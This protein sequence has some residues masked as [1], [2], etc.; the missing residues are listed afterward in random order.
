M[1]LDGFHLA[2]EGGPW[3]SPG[4]GHMGRAH[5]T[6]IGSGARL[7]RALRQWVPVH[8]TRERPFRLLLGPHPSASSEQSGGV[9]TT[10][11][12]TGAWWCRVEQGITYSALSVGTVSEHPNLAVAERPR[13]WGQGLYHFTLS[14]KVQTPAVFPSSV[15]LAARSPGS[16]RDLSCLVISPAGNP[17]PLVWPAGPDL[18]PA[19]CRPAGP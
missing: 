16:P 2:A 18:L 1:L 4:S 3:A 11:K 9:R 8:C 17:Q 19:L 15:M 14:D 6:R 12:G 13:H 7:L 5:L 10:G